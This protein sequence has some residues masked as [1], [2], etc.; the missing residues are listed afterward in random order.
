[1]SFAFCF[2]FVVVLFIRSTENL[3]KRGLN[4]VQ[5]SKN[6]SHHFFSHPTRHST[7]RNP[8]N[9]TS[10]FVGWWEKRDRSRK[11]KK[12]KILPRFITV[13]NWC[14]NNSS[15]VPSHLFPR[16]RYFFPCEKHEEKKEIKFNGWRWRG[17]RRRWEH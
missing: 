11:K 1:M 9:R 16:C 3:V 8:K 7:Q 12:K 17:A 14:Q 2:F 13:L 15:K 4:N 6:F 5:P 10:S